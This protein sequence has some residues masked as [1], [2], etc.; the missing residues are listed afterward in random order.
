MPSFL[1]STKT[2]INLVCIPGKKS[3]RVII[4]FIVEKMDDAKRIKS[5][6]IYK[7]FI[8]LHQSRI[9]I[10]KTAPCIH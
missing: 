3:G 7:V 4:C 9:D 6:K 1:T 8:I 2:Y 10:Y 5:F